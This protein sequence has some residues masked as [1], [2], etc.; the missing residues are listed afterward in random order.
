MSKYFFYFKKDEFQKNCAV[1]FFNSN[2]SFYLFICGPI[3]N[4]YNKII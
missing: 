1:N 2:I 3:I 4:K